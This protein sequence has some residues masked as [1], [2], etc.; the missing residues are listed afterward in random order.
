MSGHAVVVSHHNYQG[1]RSYEAPDEVGVQAEPATAG[2][3]RGGE[4]GRKRRGDEL[5]RHVTQEAAAAASGEA[6]MGK[7]P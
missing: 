3:R 7:T 2:E 5:R 6:R 1:C 4:G